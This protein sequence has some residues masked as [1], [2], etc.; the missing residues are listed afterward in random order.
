MERPRQAEVGSPIATRPDGVTD[1]ERTTSLTRYLFQDAAGMVVQLLAH[2]GR[3]HAA[4]MAQK[5]V[6]AQFLFKVLH[7]LAHRGLGDPQ[8]FGSA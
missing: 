2:I 6:D 1:C 7:L 3:G 5:Q 8:H 4:R